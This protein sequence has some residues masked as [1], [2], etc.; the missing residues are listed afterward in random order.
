METPA[1]GM[2]GSHLTTDKVK[3]FSPFLFLPGIEGITNPPIV[4][5]TMV[6]QPAIVIA[7]KK[8]KTWVSCHVTERLRH[9]LSLLMVSSHSGLS[10]SIG[11]DEA[12]QECS[13]ATHITNK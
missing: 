12:N 6:K 5:K 7:S 9:N 13:E 10:S 8:L 11:D 2:N 3:R 4:P 1:N